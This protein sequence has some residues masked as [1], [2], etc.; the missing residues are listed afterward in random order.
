MISLRPATPDDIHRLYEI[1]RA[2]SRQM[3][4]ETWGH[5][6]EAW[7]QHYFSQHFDC[8][9]RQVIQFHSEPIGFLDVT[10]HADHVFLA[11]IEIAPEYQCRGFGTALI[12]DVLAKG[13]E[14]HLPV[15]LQV[16]KV[17]KRAHALYERLSFV[18]TGHTDTHYLMQR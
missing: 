16:L 8:S 1:H 12:R 14:L 4:A 7:Q 3:V 2:A 13:S 15:R 17:N 6:D 9:A 10:F 5:W 18:E 11:G